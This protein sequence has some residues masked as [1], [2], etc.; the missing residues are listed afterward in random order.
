MT[1]LSPEF[2]AA[3]SALRQR[4][5]DGGSLTLQDAVLLVETQIIPSEF[6]LNQLVLLGHHK[7][8]TKISGAI[9]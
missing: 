4:L 9:T 5:T 8:I 7:L 2:V 1:T 6:P 3:L